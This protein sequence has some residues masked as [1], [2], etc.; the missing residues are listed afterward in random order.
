MAD[1]PLT[2]W[3]REGNYSNLRRKSIFAMNGT[4]SL[5]R[6]TLGWLGSML[7]AEA[8]VC[9]G[10]GVGVRFKKV[11]VVL[12]ISRCLLAFLPF[13]QHEDKAF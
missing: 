12:S 6:L 5:W 13:R 1:A 11:G 9:F 8:P 3:Q 7:I 10:M 4:I 2:E